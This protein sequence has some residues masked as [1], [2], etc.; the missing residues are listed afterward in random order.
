ML[1]VSTFNIAYNGLQKDLTELIIK[2]DQLLD[3]IKIKAE[4]P[5]TDGSIK[6]TWIF[7][8]RVNQYYFKF[9]NKEGSNYSAFSLFM[10]HVEDFGVYR[11]PFLSNSDY[12]KGKLKDRSAKGLYYREINPLVFEYYIKIACVTLKVRFRCLLPYLLKLFSY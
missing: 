6:A 4:K 1:S 12:L 9:L 11:L 2:V 10:D 8:N 5:I 7:L 3:E